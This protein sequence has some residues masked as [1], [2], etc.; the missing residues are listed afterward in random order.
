MRSGSGIR[1]APPVPSGAAAVPTG[2]PSKGTEGSVCPGHGGSKGEP[3]RAA[4]AAEITGHCWA[5]GG[6]WI[7]TGGSCGSARC[8]ERG[9]RWGMLEKKRKRNERKGKRGKRK[10]RK[11]R[12]RKNKRGKRERKN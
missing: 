1:G 7:N 4:I 3:G 8:P 11:R 5:P 6:R 9:E 10:K 2:S 12:I